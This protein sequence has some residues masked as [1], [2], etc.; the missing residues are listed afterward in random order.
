MKISYQKLTV[1]VNKIE[2]IKVIPFKI[3]FILKDDKITFDFGDYEDEFSLYVRNLH[4][5][6]LTHKIIKD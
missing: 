4:T 2:S 5:L 3:E 6:G 1:D